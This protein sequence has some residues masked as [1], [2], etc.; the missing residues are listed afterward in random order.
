V[1]GFLEAWREALEGLPVGE[2]ALSDRVDCV[3]L[4]GL[5]GQAL[6]QLARE[7]RQSAEMETL[8]PFAGDLIALEEQR[9]ELGDV[10]PPAVAERLVCSP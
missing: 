8:V 2:F 6:R 3:L 1:R 10:D 7:E 5:V 9:R 4:K